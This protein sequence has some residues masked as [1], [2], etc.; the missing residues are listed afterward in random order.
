MPGKSAPSL[1]PTITA[2]APCRA[3]L[4]GGTIDLWPLYL[5]HPGALTLN[6]AVEILTSCRVTPLKGQRIELCSIDTHCE[7]TFTNLDELIASRSHRHVLAAYLV[8]FFAPERGL[9]VETDDYRACTLSRR[10]GRRH[11]RS[12]AVVSVSSGCIDAEFCR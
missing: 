5:F 12:L 6:F 10:P 11:D 8:R 1:Q 9:R 3:D 7:E 2:H 4:A